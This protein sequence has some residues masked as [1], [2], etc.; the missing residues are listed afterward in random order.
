MANVTKLNPG[1]AKRAVIY[2]RYSTDMQNEKSVD[3]QI[4]YC[5]KFAER[6]GVKIVGTYC[7]KGKSGASMFERD[8]LLRMMQ[9]S[10]KGI[11][12]QVITEQL[13]RLSRDQEDTAGI[14]K[15]LTHLGIEINTPSEGV[16]DQ[17][18]VGVRG[19]IS[20]IFLKDLSEKVRRG[21]AGAVQR[22]KVPGRAAFGYRFVPGQPGV[23]EINPDTAPTVERI[24]REH[25]QGIT[26]RKIAEGL[27]RDGIK[28]P[29]AAKW[30][31]QLFCKGLDQGN[32]LLDNQLYIGKI[33]WFVGRHVKDPD[34]GK[35]HRRMNDV[36]ERVTVDAPHLRIIDD[37][38]F[39]AA[40]AARVA[41]RTNGNHV[42]RVVTR[43]TDSVLHGL[44][45]CG[46]CGGQMRLGGSRKGPGGEAIPYVSCKTAKTN[47]ACTNGRTYL[48]NKI[49]QATIEYVGGVFADSERMQKFVDSYESTFAKLQRDAKGDKG[50]IEKELSTVD[51]KVLRLVNA[52]E[53]GSMPE[54]VI[55]PRIQKL[56]AERVGLRERLAMADAEAVKVVMHPH[57]VKKWHS[58]LVFLARQL[59]S[60][61]D[62]P[63]A[64]QAMRTLLAGVV[65]HPVKRNTPYQIEP[66][67]HKAALAGADL[68]PPQRAA[69]EIAREYGVSGNPSAMST[70]SSQLLLKRRYQPSAKASDSVI[71]LGIAIAA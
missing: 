1:K 21:H 52:L 62:T 5:T 27:N 33:Q 29:R 35:T 4:A 68:F 7:D 22:G 11:F 23:L 26:P 3:D 40:H 60:G 15:R 36:S 39:Q 67:A 8:G 2:A 25:A 42:G 70:T 65:V 19:L 6:E 69:S 53:A 49:E 38:T 47:G 51:A 43:R 50:K 18:K 16:A 44:L 64:R 14:Y 57:A 46:E 9:D 41:R 32:G 66:L 20:S 63:E 45:I 37:K 30:H 48:L 55:Y 24:F 12:D 10:K 56:E 71:S 31:H 28:P 59:R 13:D 34:T 54:H 58:D 61:K 17:I